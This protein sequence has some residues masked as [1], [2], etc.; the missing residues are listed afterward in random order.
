MS[1]SAPPIIMRHRSFWFPTLAV[2]IALWPALALGAASEVKSSPAPAWKLKDVEGRTV[3]SEDFRGKVMVLDFW[4]TWCPP[5]R[6]EIP[7]YVELQQKYGAEGLAVIGVSLDQE[8]AGVVKQFIASRKINY[9]IVMGDEQIADT[10]GGVEAIPT[11]FII[12]RTGMIRFR[13]VGSMSAADF[14]AV[15]RPILK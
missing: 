15:L 1:W 10:F 2:A 9:Q 6:A 14:E 12:D 3:S 11:T 5:C 8:G 13:K 4:A 7:G